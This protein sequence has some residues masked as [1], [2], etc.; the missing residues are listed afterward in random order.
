MFK[1]FF[2]VVF[3]LFAFSF[4]AFANRYVRIIFLGNKGSGKT[5]L[6]SAYFG[7]QRNPDLHTNPA[8]SEYN[9]NG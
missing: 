6:L 5:E 8:I 2:S 3:M 1:K 9:R 7:K 4:P